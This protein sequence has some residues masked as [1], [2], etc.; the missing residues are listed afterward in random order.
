MSALI[1][2]MKV[3]L[4]TDWKPIAEKQMLEVGFKLDQS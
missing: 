4:E 3:L 2:R 1:E